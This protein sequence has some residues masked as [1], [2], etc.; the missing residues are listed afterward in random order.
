MY[1]RRLVVLV[2]G[3]ME[4]NNVQQ[5]TCSVWLWSLSSHMYV[6]VSFCS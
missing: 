2:M 1:S 6:D 4:G 5:E 3:I